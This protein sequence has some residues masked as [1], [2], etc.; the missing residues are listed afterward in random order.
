MSIKSE[1][2]GNA[3]VVAIKK[4]PYRRF[5]VSPLSHRWNPF[6]TVY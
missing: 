6:L 3:R 4:P 1:I 2:N 5:F